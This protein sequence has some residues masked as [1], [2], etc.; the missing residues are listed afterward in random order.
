MLQ[1][2]RRDVPVMYT[3]KKYTPNVDANI[4][5]INVFYW[6]QLHARAFVNGSWHTKLATIYHAF[7]CRLSKSSE[8]L[9][10][11]MGHA[12]SNLLPLRLQL[13]NNAQRFLLYEDFAWLSMLEKPF[14]ESPQTPWNI[15]PS[16]AFMWPCTMR[17]LFMFV[18]LS[19]TCTF[20]VTDDITS[21]SFFLSHQQ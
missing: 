16:R 12:I 17:G 6:S 15:S 13:R 2:A 7:S 9:C 3:R 1:E 8:Q 14:I 5:L 20:G 11:T 4:D 10:V 19:Y 18:K 21:K